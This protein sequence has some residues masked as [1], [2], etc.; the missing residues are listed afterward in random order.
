MA[1][2]FLLHRAGGVF[3]GIRGHHPEGLEKVL[4][5]LKSAGFNLVSVRD[6]VAAAKGDKALP[7]HS[8]AFTMDDGY[9]DQLEV[10]APIFVKHGVPLT[11]FLATGSLDGELWP[12]DAK[13]HWMMLKT[14]KEKIEIPIG[15]QTFDWAMGSPKERL[16][17]RREMQEIAATLPNGKL[18]KFQNDLENACGVEL[19][20]HAPKEFMPAT[21]EQ[22]RALE[23]QG[24]DFAP[25]THSHMVLSRLTDEQTREELAKSLVRLKSETERSVPFLAYP[26][27]MHQH[28]GRR[29]V[30]LASEIGLAAA[31]AVGNGYSRWKNAREEKEQRFCL[32]RYSLPERIEDSVWIASG[33]ECVRQTCS[34]RFYKRRLLKN[35]VQAFVNNVDFE[36]VSR[37][38]FVCKGN[39][40]RSPYAEKIAKRLGVRAV[41]CGTNVIFSKPVEMLAALASQ[42]NGLDLSEHRSKSIYEIDVCETDCIVMMDSMQLKVVKEIQKKSNC[43]VTMLSLWGSRTVN[44]IFDPYGGTVKEF[45]NCYDMIDDSVKN[46]ILKRREVDRA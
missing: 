40:C 25:H 36:R 21:W 42:V 33:L 7:P 41:S 15:R 8:V 43:Q 11:V 31:F 17:A 24:V 29:E 19:P 27:G 44:E 34:N 26:V 39:V 20:K 1:T 14:K 10:L 5:G 18:E 9:R 37:W 22:V 35:E 46:L 13:I 6:V 45:L 12:W 3:D 30:V 32:E 2:V 4:V 28:F 38:I 16:L 23:E